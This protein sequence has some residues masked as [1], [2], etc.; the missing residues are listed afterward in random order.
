MKLTNFL[1][2]QEKVEIKHSAHIFI[3][4]RSIILIDLYENKK[5]QLQTCTEQKL[6]SFTSRE[7]KKIIGALNKNNPVCTSAR[8]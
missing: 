6:F 3:H 7:H 5:K 1:S 2:I 8:F 4:F